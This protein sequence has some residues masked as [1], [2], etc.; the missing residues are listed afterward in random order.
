MGLATMPKSKSKSKAKRLMSGAA[1]SGD[2]PPIPQRVNELVRRYGLSDS[3]PSGADPDSWLRRPELPD[4]SEILGRVGDG[5]DGGASSG[6]GDNGANDDEDDDDAEAVDVPVNNIDG[7]WGSREE[8]LRTH[9]E[10]LR[11]DVVAP[12]RDAVGLVRKTPGMV[13]NEL[14][15][16]YDKVSS[17]P[18]SPPDVVD[19][20]IRCMSPATPSPHK[21][22]LLVFS[23]RRLERARRFSG[24]SP[25][26]SCREA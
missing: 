9:Y 11:E 3:H 4:V 26:D 15:C 25:S 18:L 2:Q 6:S 5:K 20:G 17:T 19:F 13:D 24:S 7:P 8:Y 16:I 22:P 1:G 14:A 23:S 10:L 12:L 21:D